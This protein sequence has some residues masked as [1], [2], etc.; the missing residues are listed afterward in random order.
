MVL[1]AVQIRLIWVHGLVLNPVPGWPEPR[2]ASACSRP[3]LEERRL[4]W[5]AAS[6]GFPGS[7][8]R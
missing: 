7:V 6:R 2:E 8:R 5:G 1:N 4:A 3:H